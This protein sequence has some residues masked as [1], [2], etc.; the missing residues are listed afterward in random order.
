MSASLKA[1]SNPS[2][3]SFIHYNY[4]HFTLKTYQFHGTF[5]NSNYFDRATHTSLQ[6]FTQRFQGC[7]GCLTMIPD[8][9]RYYCTNRPSV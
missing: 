8:S 9:L 1:T 3:Q 4:F 5:S 6:S 2:K 7:I